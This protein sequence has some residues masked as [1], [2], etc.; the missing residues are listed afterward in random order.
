MKRSLAALLLLGIFSSQVAQASFEDVTQ[1]D[2]YAQSIEWMQDN[3]VI[4]GT[5]DGL[6]HPNDCVKRSEM[7]KF[8]YASD[9]IVI[10]P[11]VGEF[12][13]T[14]TSFNDVPVSHWAA[15]YVDLAATDGLVQGFEDG[16]FH[17]DAC[18]TRAEGITMALNY[19]WGAQAYAGYVPYFWYGEN[20]DVPATE[21]FYEPVNYAIDYD[22]VGMEHQTWLDANEGTMYY[23]NPTEGMSRAEV[24][25]MIYRFRTVEDNG[26]WYY[27]AW[28]NP[29]PLPGNYFHT[30]C[31]APANNSLNELRAEAV[32]PKDSEVV[33]NVNQSNPTQMENLKELLSQWDAFGL[34]ALLVDQYNMYRPER[35]SYERTVA[36]FVEGDW[37]AS[38]ALSFPKNF[39]WD[40]ELWDVEDSELDMYLSASVENSQAFMDFLGPELQKAMPDMQCSVEN[41]AVYW[42]SQMNQFYLANVGNLFF[43]SNTPENR[44]LG[45]ER[46]RSGNGYSS[47]HNNLASV[48]A[49]MEELSSFVARE[50]RNV[51]LDFV[52]D[53]LEDLGQVEAIVEA[54]E[55][56]LRLSS[57]TEFIDTDSAMI[58]P[59]RNAG[60]NLASR[61][62][63]EGLLFYMEE[64]DLSLIFQSMTSNFTPM[65][66]SKALAKET[67]TSYDLLLENFATELSLS[68]QEVKLLLDSPYAIAVSDLESF[69]PGMGLYVDLVGSQKQE[70]AGRFSKDI[71]K[72]VGEL[73]ASS[74]TTQITSERL[75]SSN[76]RLVTIPNELLGPSLSLF[77]DSVEFTYGLTQDNT[78]VFALYPNFVESYQS[79]SKVAMDADYLKALKNV[80]SDPAS[81]SYMDLAGML[82]MAE[83]YVNV[84]GTEQDVATFANVKAAFA[85]IEF[86]IG[87]KWVDGDSLHSDAYLGR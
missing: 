7:L 70:I 75:P 45:L 46:A 80:E 71:D 40:Q 77:V 33:F 54:E 24:A 66:L 27:S 37:E 35:Y 48:S 15:P 18:M 39:D 56:G 3:G 9:G 19:Y 83:D 74:G 63:G 43:V 31:E 55:K 36:P 41:N 28:Y 51:G 8:L 44:T 16:G 84:F 59:Y 81:V 25:E 72:M 17:P 58:Q 68:A 32:A 38:M 60:L 5:G 22:L 2:P 20:V 14:T 23:F 57:Q 50:Y 47:T 13:S 52:A 61:V 10:T 67:A 69:I 4:Q 42:T 73:I 65:V 49:N 21:W 26:L 85:P 34:G 79:E 87:V 76:L 82:R 30:A 6:F 29:Y 62:P 64:Q 53:Y 86:V 12:D 1:E 78:Y 11:T